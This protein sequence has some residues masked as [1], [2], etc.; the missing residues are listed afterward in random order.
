MELP[1][2]VALITTA[3]KDRYERGRLLHVHKNAVTLQDGSVA[4]VRVLVQTIAEAPRK[5]NK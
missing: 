4:H 1:E 3:W 5:E 2:L